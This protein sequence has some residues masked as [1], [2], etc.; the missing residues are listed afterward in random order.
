MLALN[1]KT[2]LH[3]R[4]LQNRIN[5]KLPKVNA[6]VAIKNNNL[7]FCFFAFKPGVLIGFDLI[8]NFCADLDLS[9]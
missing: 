7:V 6:T 5:K 2:K 3:Q 1:L 8:I 4:R 9:E